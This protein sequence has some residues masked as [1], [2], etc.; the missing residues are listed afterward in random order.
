L[1]TT[2][3]VDTSVS[4]T[5]TRPAAVRS[6]TTVRTRLRAQAASQ[7]SDT[8][9]P[10]CTTPRRSVTV[11]GGRALATQLLVA[12]AALSRRLL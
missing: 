10:A 2:A 5:T 6:D 1:A 8:P 11:Y 4:L 3:P 9:Q 12:P 7:V